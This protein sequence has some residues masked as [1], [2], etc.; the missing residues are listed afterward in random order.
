MLIANAWWMWLLASLCLMLA[1]VLLPG[2]F[3]F[4]FFGLGA[5]LVA[6]IEIV[7]PLPLTASLAI[8]AASSVLL[9]IAL[10]S[11][12]MKSNLFR[13]SQTGIVDTMIGCT[14]TAS[15]AIPVGQ[16]GKVEFRGA[17]WTGLNTGTSALAPGQRYRVIKA[18]GLLLE[19]AS[20]E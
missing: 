2:S 20:E 9:M 12:L 18:D 5:L 15:E 1:E 3:F 17:P 11:R 4:F 7:I 13:G 10:R 6:L 14:G 8:F 19:I 16:R